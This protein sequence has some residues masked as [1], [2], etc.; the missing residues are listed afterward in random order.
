MES[1]LP[2]AEVAVS[3]ALTE[4]MLETQFGQEDQDEGQTLLEPADHGLQLGQGR[5]GGA[6][7]LVAPLVG[8][9]PVVAPHVLQ[10][11]AA[12]VAAVVKV[13]VGLAVVVGAALAPASTLLPGRGHLN[14]HVPA[15][16]GGAQH[17]AGREGGGGE[18]ARREAREAGEERWRGGRFCLQ[19][20]EDAPFVHA[21]LGA[22]S[23]AAIS[24]P[25]G[26][27]KPR[28]VRQME[29]QSPT[30]DWGTSNSIKNVIS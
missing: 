19:T 23:L 25:E 27:R 10:Q 13:V 11:R 29:R 17:Q 2:P 22:E 18:A 26:K 6:R 24:G 9:C 14:E 8:V 15:A 20:L 1:P 21:G 28:G 16:G 5:G 4:L 7:L 3:L 30:G 12:T